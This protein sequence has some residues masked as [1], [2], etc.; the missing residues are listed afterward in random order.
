[1]M[2]T[3]TAT[4]LFDEM[5]RLGHE[6][7]PF[8]FAVDY[9]VREGILIP[10]PEQ[11]RSVLY[12][13]QEFSNMP[14]NMGRCSFHLALRSYPRQFAIYQQ[15]FNKIHRALAVG[16][17][18]LANL[19]IAT[20]IEMDCSLETIAQYAVAPYKL[21]VPGRFVCFSPERFVSIRPAT[22]GQYRI[23]T[24][25][26]KGTIDASIPNAE[27]VILSSYKETAEHYTIV[28]LMRSD[29]ARVGQRV[30][31]NKFRYI[32]RIETQNGGLLQV[33]SL[34]SATLP[35]DTLDR[36]GTILGTLL[37]AGSIT[38][39][40]KEATIRAIQEAETEPRG[41]YSGVF[42]YFDGSCLESAVMIR[43]IEEQGDGAFYFH[44]GGGITINSKAEDEYKE[45]IEKIYIPV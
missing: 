12:K 36:L 31:V 28:D 37:P 21:Y 41:Y 15:Q 13:V 18:F 26:M 23:E 5:N 39:A 35:T 33:S 42:G 30:Q 17:S 29:L 2:T 14:S 44:S 43:F 25:P 6:R 10:Y 7:T 20:P 1:M 32:D 27:E 4:N 22:G 40:P 8:L 45:V 11:Q 24:C 38:G 9:E 19:T 16:N 34:I 3:L